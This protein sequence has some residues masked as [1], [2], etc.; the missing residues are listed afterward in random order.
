MYTIF[1]YGMHKFFILYQKILRQKKFH[2]VKIFSYQ[3][4]VLL[5]GTRDLSGARDL[6]T[7]DVT[8][9]QHAHVIIG[10]LCGNIDSCKY[11]TAA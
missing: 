1:F 10:S 4:H 6:K 9:H 3:E 7:D 11:V 2:A 8:Q 5:A